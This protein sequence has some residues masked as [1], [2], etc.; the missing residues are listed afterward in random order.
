MNLGL[1]KFK[2]GEEIVAEYLEYDDYYFV[3]NTAGL[4]A[5]EDFHWQL[6]TWMP[7]TNVRNGHKLPKSEI[8]FV[9]E[10]SDDMKTYYYN[11][12]TALE[13]GIKNVDLKQ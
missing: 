11:W 2:Y 3:K 13:N 5:T 1:F 6:M 9:T 10:L 7:Y 4:M 8:W 12:K